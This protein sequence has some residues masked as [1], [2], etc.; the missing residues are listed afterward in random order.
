[1]AFAWRS[2]SSA[3]RRAV[4]KMLSDEKRDLSSMVAVKE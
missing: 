2:V 3:A 4:E 1:M